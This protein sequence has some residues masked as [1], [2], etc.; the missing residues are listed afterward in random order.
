MGS[1]AEAQRD[2]F[3]ARI[4]RIRTGNSENTMGRI[5]VGP[6]EEVRAE[7]KKKRRARK[8]RV[9]AAQPTES[10]GSLVIAVPLALAVG[11]FAFAAG[12]LGAFHLFTGQGMYLVEVPFP[13][14]ELWGDIALATILA[15]LLAWSLRLGHGIR[16]TALLLG[17]AAM[18]A[19]EVYVM[20]QFQNT[21]ERF[22]T[23]SYVTATL[24]QPVPWF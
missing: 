6:R 1:M 8:V 23:P 9:G 5:E 12:R 24:A 4:D 2:G 13:R 3:D 21:F 7:K 11:A 22:Y 15:V 20:E 14:V 19:G 16:R 10:F 18:M 17:F